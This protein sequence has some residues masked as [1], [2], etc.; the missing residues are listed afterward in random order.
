MKKFAC[1]L[2]L[3]SL[4]SGSALA[5]TWDEFLNGDGDA[6]DLP[7]TLQV[8]QGVGSLDSITGRIFGDTDMFCIRITDPQAFSALVHIAGDGTPIEN[9]EGGGAGEGTTLDTQLWLFDTSGHGV[10]FNDDDPLSESSL[11]S[12][13]SG[14]YVPA[15]GLYF[16]ALS[17][18]DRDAVDAAGAPIWLDS[19]Y[20]SERTPDGPGAANAIFGWDNNV[21]NVGFDY[22]IELTGASYHLTPEP[23]SLALIGLGALAFVRRR[24]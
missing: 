22:E 16:L 7:A 13:L 4:A 20:R 2:L 9:G 24:A 23:A 19:P 5:G 10:A 14:R 15:P 17:R 12:R 21:D 11:L 8:T 1:S 3:A 6:G 18:Y